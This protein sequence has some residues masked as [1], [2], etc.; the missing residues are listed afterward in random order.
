[1]HNTIILHFIL[2]VKLLL[3]NSSKDLNSQLCLSIIFVSDDSPKIQ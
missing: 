1:M 2:R 3:F